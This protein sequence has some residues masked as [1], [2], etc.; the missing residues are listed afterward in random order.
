MRGDR[1]VAETRPL[2]ETATL[3]PIGLAAGEFV[4]P[5]DFDEPLPMMCSISLKV[6]KLRVDRRRTTFP[7]L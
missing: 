7:S 3:R 1:P 4:V 5:D 6:M 2:T